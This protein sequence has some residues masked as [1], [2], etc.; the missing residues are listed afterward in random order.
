M[1]VFGVCTPDLGKYPD[2]PFFLLQ[3]FGVSDHNNM[4]YTDDYTRDYIL[5]LFE[6]HSLPFND[7]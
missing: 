1:C 6:A 4:G 3:I 2:Y 5:R 7:S